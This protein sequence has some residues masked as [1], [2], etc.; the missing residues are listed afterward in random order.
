MSRSS[1]GRYATAEF[2]KNVYDVKAFDNNDK[3]LTIER[4]SGDIYKVAH[5]PSTVKLTY[6]LYGDYADGTYDGIDSTSAHLNMPATF[7]WIE[8]HEPGADHF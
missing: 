8:G 5:H 6:T 1:A 3:P 4:V 7:M 2:G